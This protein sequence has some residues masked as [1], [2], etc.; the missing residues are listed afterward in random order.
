MKKSLSAFLRNWHKESFLGARH[1]TVRDRLLELG[2]HGMQ[3][4]IQGL[5]V[6]VIGEQL[7]KHYI[8]D[9]DGSICCRGRNNYNPPLTDT[10]SIETLYPAS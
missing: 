5:C 9:E 6:D 10:I 1:G 3:S 2:G 8:I 4:V 7:D